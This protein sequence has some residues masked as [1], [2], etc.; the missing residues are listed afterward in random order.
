MAER[1]LGLG[2]ARG[3]RGVVAAVVGRGRRPADGGAGQLLEARHRAEVG[4]VERVR[5]GR[6]VR[7]RLLVLGLLV[8]GLLLAALERRPARRMPPGTRLM[9]MTVRLGGVLAL[10]RAEEVRVLATV[11]APLELIDRLAPMRRHRETWRK[12]AN[13]R[14]AFFVRP[15][16]RRK[17][18]RA[19]V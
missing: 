2:A 1:K 19:R 16:R 14:S 7:V 9:M 5:V 4:R 11:R 15:R 12:R 6:R 3:V 18:K 17:G 10:L 8:L 13:H